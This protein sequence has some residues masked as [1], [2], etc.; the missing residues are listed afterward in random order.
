M[1]PINRFDPVIFLFISNFTCLVFFMFNDMR[2]EVFMCFVLI[3]GIIY[4][5]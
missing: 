5:H 2:H 1:N 3:G 4:Q